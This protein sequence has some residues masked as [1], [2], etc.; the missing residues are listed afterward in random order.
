MRG[1]EEEEDDEES[2]K[3][4][5]DGEEN[6]KCTPTDLQFESKNDSVLPLD[7]SYCTAALCPI[8]QVVR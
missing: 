2:S 3:G 7:G 8:T 1:E 6:R 5:E 4:D